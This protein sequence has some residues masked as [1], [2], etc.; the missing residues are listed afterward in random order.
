MD[1]LILY[2]EINNLNYVFFVGER[3]EQNNLKIIYKSEVNLQGIENNRISDLEI[4]YSLLQKNIF[5]IE[6]KFNHTFKEIVLILDNFNPEFINISG[7]KKLN[8]TQILRENI[9][10]ILNNLKSYVNMIESKKTILHIFNS[11]FY[12][13]NKKIDNLPIGLFGDFYS[14]ELSFTL[15]NSNEYKNLKNIFDKCGLKVKK[16]LSKSYIKGAHINEQNKNFETFF[17]IKI[18]E[19]ESKI[20]YFENNSLKSEQNFQFGTNIIVK[21]ISKITSLKTESVKLILREI[22]F[23][24]EILE[25]E[26]IDEKFFEGKSNRKIKKKLIY[27]IALARV[28]EI[29]EIFIFKNINFKYYSNISKNISLEIDEGIELKGLNQIFKTIFSKNGDFVLNLNNDLSNENLLNTAN[30]LVH[31]GWK[32]EV[33]PTSETKKSLIGRLFEAIFN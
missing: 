13:D 33:I 3:D 18:S 28:L 6:K 9:T 21:D 17:H 26:L 8:G 12:L 22:E 27:D 7:F 25:N 14:H 31:F 24:G 32:K 10:Y 19:N 2:L 1:S 30:K 15:L 16:I 20:F 29:L 5:I 4:I 23:K 11:K